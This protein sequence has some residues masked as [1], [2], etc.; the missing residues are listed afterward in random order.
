MVSVMVVLAV[1]APLVAV[2]A[3][4]YVPAVAV[5]GLT[6]KS[7]IWPEF[8]VA[9]KVC[10][11]QVTPLGSPVTVRFAVPLNPPMPVTATETSPVWPKMS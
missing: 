11:G 6:T 7:R 8:T 10:C 1:Y 9:V 2:T 5:V 3:M 4:G